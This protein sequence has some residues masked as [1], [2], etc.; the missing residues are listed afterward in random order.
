MQ[1]VSD[2][3]K[4]FVSRYFTCEDTLYHAHIIRQSDT[5]PALL[6]EKRECYRGAMLSLFNE[7]HHAPTI[8]RS[9]SFL[10]CIVPYIELGHWLGS[11]KLQVR[12]FFRA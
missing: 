12:A 2:W 9:H 1:H 4:A 8:L 5:N 11:I 7:S 10:L 3:S 6:V